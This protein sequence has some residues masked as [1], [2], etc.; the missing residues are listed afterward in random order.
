MATPVLVNTNK[1]WL[2]DLKII[3][4]QTEAMERFIEYVSELGENNTRSGYNNLGNANNMSLMIVDGSDMY[5]NGQGGNDFISTFNE[6]FSNFGPVT[7]HISGNDTVYAGS[8]NDTV[9]SGAGNDTLYGGS[10]NDKLRGGDGHDILNG[11]SGAD[12]LFGDEGLDLLNGGSG[13]DTLSGGVGRDTLNGGVDADVLIGGRD[14]DRL[15]GGYGADT[16]SFVAATDLGFGHTDVIEDFSRNQAD[17]ID[18]SGIDANDTLR[19]NQAFRLVDGPSAEAGTMWLGNFQEA[20]EF[21]SA[22]QRVY[23]NVGDGPDSLITGSSLHDF[24]LV[25]EFNDPAITGLRAQDF[26]F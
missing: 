7:S 13:N 17:K 24:E 18:L 19:G 2:A 12:Q 5:V 21:S 16:F 15:I 20:T 25:V 11:G 9:H 22:R 3:P 10:G 8:G 4:Y 14:A 1:T 6:T 26:I 23:F